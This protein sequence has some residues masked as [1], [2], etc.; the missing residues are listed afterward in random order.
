[1]KKINPFFSPLWK[2]EKDLLYKEIKKISYISC[3]SCK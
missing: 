2:W 1:M 3:T